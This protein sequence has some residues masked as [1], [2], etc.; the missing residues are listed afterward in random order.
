MLGKIV[1]LP[2]PWVSWRIFWVLGVV[3]GIPIFYYVYSSDQPSRV[4]TPLTRLAAPLVDRAAQALPMPERPTRLL[5]LPLAGD[6]TGQLRDLLRDSI[7]RSGKYQP[8]EAGNLTKHLYDL[9]VNLPAPQSPEQAALM[10]KALPGD[11]ALG[12]EIVQWRALTGNAGTPPAMRF[13]LYLV[14]GEGTQWSQQLDLA[15]LE[16]LSPGHSTNQTS[17]FHW[18][19]AIS[20]WLLLG[21]ALPFLFWPLTR[22]MLRRQDNAA[23]AALVGLYSLLSLAVAGLFCW[24]RLP[25][26]WLSVFL[27]LASLV[28]LWG[29]YRLCSWLEHRVL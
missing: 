14:D 8:V 16:T 23:N 24:D 3:L 17:W 12:G 19:A 6:S 27:I 4:D 26:T 9:G 21:A 13:R 29:Q 28:A 20:L 7:G 5:F 10:F 18:L 22:E 11:L 25:G 1:L 15:D 2:F